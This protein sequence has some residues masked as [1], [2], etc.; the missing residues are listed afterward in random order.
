MTALEHEAR[1]LVVPVIY[2]SVRSERQ[3]IKAA[4]F[5]VAEL[6]RRG[7]DAVLIDPLQYTLPLL[8]KMYKE[9]DPGTA[10]AQLEELGALYKRADGFAIVCGEYNHSIPPALS[11]LLDYFLED[12]DF[13]PSAIVCYSGGYFGGVRAA[14]QLRAMLC[15]LGTSS[16]PSLL[17]IPHVARAFTDAGVPTDSTFAGRHDLFFKEFIWYMEALRDKRKSGVPY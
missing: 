17:P 14:M 13:R 7:C 11:N 12:Y 5:V 15:E 8:D 1:Q 10:P 9:Y 6:A 2:G 16:I 4:R 3:G